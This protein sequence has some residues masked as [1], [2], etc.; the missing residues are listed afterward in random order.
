MTFYLS[1]F[2]LSF[3]CLHIIKMLFYSTGENQQVLFNYSNS[4]G[5]K[6][7]NVITSRILKIANKS[8]LQFLGYMHLPLCK[9]TE[10]VFLLIHFD[11][12]FHKNYRAA[13]KKRWY[14]LA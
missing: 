14:Y 2:F 9:E 11:F 8:L 12:V 7:L 3:C 6:L 1:F 4:S 5:T 10:L 13:V